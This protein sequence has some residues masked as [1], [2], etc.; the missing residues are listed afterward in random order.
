MKSRTGS[1][2]VVDQRQACGQPGEALLTDRP[3]EP[4]HPAEV[5]VHRHCR[6]ADALDEGAERHHLTAREHLG[7][8][9][10][11]REANFGISG[12]RHLRHVT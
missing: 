9:L 12:S 4:G 5:G 6:R 11:Q 7:G 2:V 10:D 1:D 8:T 3:P